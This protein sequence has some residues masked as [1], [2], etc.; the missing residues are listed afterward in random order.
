MR[1]AGGVFP[2]GGTPISP[3][4]GSVSGEPQLALDAAGDALVVWTYDDQSDPKPVY[5]NTPQHLEGASRP[6]GGT[7]GVPA[8]LF[9][10]PANLRGAQAGSPSVA[11]DGFGDGLAVFQNFADGAVAGQ[12]AETV[13]ATATTRPARSCGR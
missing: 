13:Q 10:T 7:F 8:S 9:D 4:T 11:I 12:G 6:A 5:S 3:T 2:V 1:P